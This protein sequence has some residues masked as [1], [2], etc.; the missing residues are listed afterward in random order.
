MQLNILWHFG[1]MSGVTKHCWWSSRRKRRKTPFQKKRELARQLSKQEV[2]KKFTNL[3]S[4]WKNENERKEKGKGRVPNDAEKLKNH[5]KTHTTW[6]LQIHSFKKFSY[7]T[8]TELL[9][10]G[11]Q[12]ADHIGLFSLRNDSHW[13]SAFQRHQAVTFRGECRPPE[14]SLSGMMKFYKSI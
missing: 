9:Q 1:E 10:N 11:R 7:W 2:E 12:A 4:K 3:S 14:R 8:A 13:W 6:S 5:I